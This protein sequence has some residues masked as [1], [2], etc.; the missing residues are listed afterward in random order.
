MRSLGFISEWVLWYYA[1]LTKAIAMENQLS[2]F[3]YTSRL[4]PHF[5][6]TGVA[7]I[8]K[9]ARELNAIRGITG[10]LMFDGENFSQY[11]EGPTD[12]IRALEKSLI[13]DDRHTNFDV[14]AKSDDL[15]LRRFK[16]WSMGFVDSGESILEQL[17]RKKDEQAVEYFSQAALAADVR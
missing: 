16:S 11:I 14:R 3:L 1:F 6:L 15:T 8:V 9:Q 7:Q 10:I 17:N 5:P 2:N 4:A 12:A 13:A